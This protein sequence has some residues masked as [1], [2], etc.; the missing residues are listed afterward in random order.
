MAGVLLEYITMKVCKK[1]YVLAADGSRTALSF[2]FANGEVRT[3]RLQEFAS[4]VQNAAAWHGLS[5]KLGDAF[6]S[7]LTTADAV[8]AF[9]ETFAQLQAGD[10]NVK[11]TGNKLAGLAA[12]VAVVQKS[13]VATVLA[14]LEK[15][16]ADK[17][18]SIR[19]HPAVKAE[20]AKQAAAKAK[21]RAKT[22]D[23][24]S[25]DSLLA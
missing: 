9:D 10:W 22:A 17:L 2:S 24:E 5:Q 7:S 19:K 23:T 15:L 12:A 13:D 20:V 14:T 16:P 18:A 21:E 8:S 4:N 1:S 3:V 6:A 11:A 25:L